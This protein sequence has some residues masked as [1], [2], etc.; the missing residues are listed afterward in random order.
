LMIAPRHTD[1]IPELE[2]LVNNFGFIPLR[3]GSI[4]QVASIGEGGV[5]LLETM[6]VLK[7]YYAAS[8]IVFVGGSMV[9]HGGHNIL[10]PAYFSKPVIFG[11][12]MH[13][14]SD[15]RDLFLSRQ[16]AIEVRNPKELQQALEGV[17]NDPHQA[18]NLGLKAREVVDSNKGATER[19]AELIKEILF[20]H[21]HTQLSL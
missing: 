5:Y 18:H 2:R 4:P 7:R 6:G 17:I 9:P 20:A 19:N 16:A 21:A 15:I 11:K 3:I 10:E 1:R 13:N 12:H 14:F 8:D